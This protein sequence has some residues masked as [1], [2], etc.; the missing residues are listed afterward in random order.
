MLTH[1]RGRDRPIAEGWWQEEAVSTS[2]TAVKGASPH[3]YVHVRGCVRVR[4][5]GAEGGKVAAVR[6][7][8]KP[9]NTQTLPLKKAVRCMAQR[10]A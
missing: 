3:T 1:P 6:P 7:D 5:G 4:E 10:M 9:A 2:A 8:T